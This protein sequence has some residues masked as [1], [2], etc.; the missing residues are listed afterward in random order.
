MKLKKIVIG[1]LLLCSSL[2]GLEYHTDGKPIYKPIDVTIE[3]MD[4]TVYPIDVT[5][6]PINTANNEVRT[7]VL[8]RGWNLIGINSEMSLET[9]RSKLGVNDL[10]AVQGLDKVYKNS[11]SQNSFIGLEKAQ[12]YWVNMAKSV[13]LEYEHLNYTEKNI[14]LKS[15]WNLVNPFGE[16]TL[17]EIITQ[18]G[19]SNLEVIQGFRKTYK[20]A[21]RDN[22]KLALND[23]I[24]FEENKGYWIKVSTEAT[25]IF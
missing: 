2:F 11:S 21:Y 4:I 7:I 3:S 24:K 18:I 23:F 14:A 20:K 19:E 22:G 1:I 15:G 6:Y 16:L 13:S 17:D 8:N 10:L 5:I 25:L 9:L 12:G